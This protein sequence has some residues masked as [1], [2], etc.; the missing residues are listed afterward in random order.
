MVRGPGAGDMPYAIR[1]ADLPDDQLQAQAAQ[2]GAELAAAGVDVNL[3]H[4]P[5]S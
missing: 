2:W 4:V 5:T 3:A 1:Q